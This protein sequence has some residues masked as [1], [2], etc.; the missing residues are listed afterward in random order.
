[1]LSF[2]GAVA[3]LILGALGSYVIGRIY[4][5]LPTTPPWWAVLAAFGTAL[6]TGILFSVA[7]A[8]RAS[9][10]DP[11]ESLARH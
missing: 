5:V 6:A 1:M 11:V 9:R 8:R 3:G 7:P 10:L 2:A 4:P